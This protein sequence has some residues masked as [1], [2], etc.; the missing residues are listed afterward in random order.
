MA[1]DGLVWRAVLAALAA[2]LLVAGGGCAGLG[3]SRLE[4]PGK[5]GWAVS[6][7]G[8]A[9]GRGPELALDGATN[10]WWQGAGEFPHW[11]EVD[12]G[13]PATVCG[14]SLQWGRMH[15]AE[16]AVLTSLEGEQW[17][18]EFETTTGDGGW[19]QVLFAP[20]RARYVRLVVRRAAGPAGAMLAGIEIQG[21]AQRPLA[22][23]DGAPAPVAEALLD[24]NPATTWKAPGRSVLELDLRRVWTVGS[25]KL[26]WGALGFASNVVVETS[27]DGEAWA[28]VGQI[29][30][31]GGDFDVLMF[32]EALEAQYLRLAFGGASGEEGFEVAELTLRGA[33]GTAR[34][35]SLL[36]VAAQQAPEGVYPDVLRGRLSY[37]TVAACLEAKGAECL[38]DEWGAFA[39]DWRSPALMPLVLAE[40]E[41]W[42]AKQAEAVEHRLAEDGVPLPETVWRLPGGVSLRIRAMPW[43]GA[44]QQVAAAEYVLANESLMVQTGRLAWVARP[45]RVPP[46]WAGGGLEPMLRLRQVMPAAGGQELWADGRRIFAVA[47]AE[48]PFGCAAFDGG[49][50]S[51]FFL[52]GETPEGTTAY[53]REGLASAAWWLDYRLEPGEQARMVVLGAASSRG[54]ARKQNAFWPEMEG[55]GAGLASAFDRAWDEASWAWR[56]RTGLFAPR[57]AQPDMIECLHAQVGRLLGLSASVNQGRGEA[58]ESVALKVAALLRA[59]RGEEAR[60]EIERVAASMT[61]DGWVPPVMMPNGK[62]GAPEEHAGWHGSQGQFVFM[63]LEDYRFSKDMDFLQR[64]YPAMKQAMER[65][66]GLR[67]GMERKEALLP[68]DERELI[69]GLLPVS[70]E[71]PK[72]AYADHVWVLLGWKELQAAAMLLG[73]DEDA[74]W[75]DR[76]YGRLKAAVGRSLRAHLDRRDSAW[77]P[78]YAEGAEFEPLTVALLFWPCAETDLV[79]PHELQSSLDYFYEGFLEA[80]TRSRQPV[81]EALML[82]PLASMGR[83]GYAREVLGALLAGRRPK[84]WHGWLSRTGA[85]L[86]GGAT[87]GVMPDPRMAAAFVLGVRGLAVQEVGRRLDLFC[88]APAEWLQHG[89]GFSVVNAPTAHGLLDLHGSWNQNRFVVEIGGEARPPEGYRLWWPRYGQPERVTANGKAVKE[90]D[91]QGMDLPHDF[92]GRI[93]AIFPNAAPH[94]RKTLRVPRGQ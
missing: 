73:Q 63:V 86:P 35:W 17:A 58:L 11:L 9:E 48:L 29:H 21:L 74:E 40:G 47:D 26:G 88:G 12:L 45:L 87:P 38:L 78:A 30:S 1:A 76:H 90:F 33:E 93:E 16:Y 70:R 37:W 14:V 57:V 77:L 75:A 80:E 72:H 50:V 65:V 2:G 31:S 91:K 67:A 62:E 55:G 28:S 34:P 27:A 7:S 15:G 84:G 8:A 69:E 19:D 68:S 92:R 85:P 53:D 10:S 83:G 56:E 25:M 64:Q 61:P 39:A 52:K 46:R 82:T 6:A 94:P 54:R 81:T 3:L 41:V 5:E 51:R 23:V 79:E 42:T 4:V 66:A 36:E 18:V 89:D 44:R 43:P 22:L 24:G 32:A 71:R 13:K 59:G 20:A 60:A 49:D